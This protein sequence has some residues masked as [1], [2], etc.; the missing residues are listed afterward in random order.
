MKKQVFTLFLIPLCILCGACQRQ[1]ADIPPE[2]AETTESAI[3]APDTESGDLYVSGG[4]VSDID[5]TKNRITIISDRTS[6]P[7]KAGERILIH[8]PLDA[9]IVWMRGEDVIT[10]DNIC[11]DDRILV[12]YQKDNPYEWVTSYDTRRVVVVDDL[13]D[14]A[15]LFALPAVEN[16]SYVYTET[17]SPDSAYEY[18]ILVELSEGGFMV[19]VMDSYRTDPTEVDLFNYFARRSVS[20]GAQT[21]IVYDGSPVTAA[22]LQIGDIVAYRAGEGAMLQESAPSRLTG[23]ISY[24]EVVARRE[25]E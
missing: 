9:D 3:P 16:H 19:A 17:F 8:I 13:D 4:T 11:V 10:P 7:V 24:L 1:T 12:Y 20:F 14:C 18:G 6:D 25:A 15:A 2:P 22:E 23:E 21:Q 5:R